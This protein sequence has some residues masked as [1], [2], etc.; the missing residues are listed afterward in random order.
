MN[1]DQR[2]ALWT[3]GRCDQ[4]IAAEI[5]CSVAT[6]C[7]WR[8]SLQLPA[9]HIKKRMN[10]DKQA[11]IVQM[12][13]DGIPLKEISDKSGVF[14]ETIRKLANRRNI[15]YSKST[16]R[17]PGKAVYGTLGYGGY[18]ELRVDLDGPYGNL[19][20]HGGDKT[21]Y[22]SLHRMRMQDKLGRK[23]LPGEI[24]HHID[25]DIYNNS[26][27]NLEVFSSVREHLDHHAETNVQRCKESTDRW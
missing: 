25:G 9:N 7:R 4:E 12:L 24:V 2:L 23:L 22:A 13:C 20:C 16:R 26:P 8:Q 17:T 1:Q 11:E 27:A 3:E 14:Q 18:V 19:V 5:G 6:V 15:P 21:G 10:A